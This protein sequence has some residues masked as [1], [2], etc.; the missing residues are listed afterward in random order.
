MKEMLKLGLILALF[1]AAACLALAFVNNLTAPIIA[2]NK[3]GKTQSAMLEIF[4]EADS[5]EAPKEFKKHDVNGISIERLL[6][7]YKGE[8]VIGVVVKSTGAT[9]DK[10][11][12]LIGINTDQSIKALRIVEITDT[13][14]FGKNA[15]EPAFY[16][17]FSGKKIDGQFVAGKNFDG[18]SGATITTKGFEKILTESTKIAL[19]YMAA[20]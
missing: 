5:F 1:A 15:E 19:E 18:I 4:P 10:A 13:Q 17:Q 6:F 16:E 2:E 9:Y 3:D 20:L 8:S 14:G 12:V 11:T 7:A